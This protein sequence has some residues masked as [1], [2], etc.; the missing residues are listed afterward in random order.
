ML[1]YW[2][3]KY[4]RNYHT[5]IVGA[6]IA[7]LFTALFLKNKFPAEKIL[8]LEK[9][10]FPAASTKNAGFACMGSITELE[11]DLASSTIEKMVALFEKRYKGLQLMRQTLGDKNIGYQARG[12]YELLTAENEQ[13]LSKIDDWNERLFSIAN[14]NAFS[15]ANVHDSNFEGFCASIK[16]ELEG[17]IDT[18]KMWQALKNKVQAAGAEILFNTAVG[19]F[20]KTEM[21]YEVF[22]KNGVS[23][24]SEKLIFCTNAFTPKLLPAVR[25]APARA[26]VL[27]TKPIKNLSF[28]G[29]YH[30]DRGY[31]YFREID[32]R[33]LFGGGRQLDK[34]GETTSQLGENEKIIKDLT[35]KLKANILPHTPFEIDYTWSGIMGL[36]QTK[37]PICQTLD[38]GLFILA[39]FGGMGVALAP[40]MARKLVGE[41][42]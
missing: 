15:Q 28:K 16:N 40:F 12:S 42:N 17:E 39:G 24:R 5:V 37:E 26:Q 20:E 3:Q 9:E 19:N 38:D 7:G 8:V 29:I 2:E 13:T 31:Y 18:G 11:E 34:E 25:I 23:F 32:G 41:V 4:F 1:S 14:S 22:I 10:I 35:A 6:G 36:P 21:G 30:F 27:I 33:V